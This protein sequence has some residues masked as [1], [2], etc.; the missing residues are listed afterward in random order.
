[1]VL[2]PGGRMLPSAPRAS[3]VVR[4]PGRGTDRLRNGRAA[5]G[6][7]GTESRKEDGGW[8]RSGPPPESLDPSSHAC[9]ADLATKG[10]AK[11]DPTAN[12]VGIF[13]KKLPI[14]I[15]GLTGLLLH[16]CTLLLRDVLLCLPEGMS[17][18]VDREGGASDRLGG[19]LLAL[20]TREV[21]VIV[22]SNGTKTANRPR[23]TLEKRSSLRA[24]AEVQRHRL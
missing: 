5:G 4:P 16:L 6:S 19:G 13:L 12:Q 20:K 9:L 21:R 7:K 3:E 18:S 11:L 17:R 2:G 8:P 10:F 1:M 15:D 14:D 23:A 22:L 24:R